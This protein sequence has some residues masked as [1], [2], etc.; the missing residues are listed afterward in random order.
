MPLITGKQ[1]NEISKTAK[2]LAEVSL[3]SIE[4]LLEDRALYTE[5]LLQV[6]TKVPGETRHET[7]LR[8]IR[9]A[10]A[11]HSGEVYGRP[12]RNEGQGND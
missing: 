2:P 11:G 7:A 5:L 9:E 8:Y 4:A 1:L 10:E 3:G 6:E 12:D